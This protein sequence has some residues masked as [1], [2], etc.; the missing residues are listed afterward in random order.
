MKNFIEHS[1]SI[2]YIKAEKIY[3]HL[4]DT[5]KN[6]LYQKRKLLKK[7]QPKIKGQSGKISG[8]ILKRNGSFKSLGDFAGNEI[9]SR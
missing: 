2:E 1:I 8:S 5:L 6:K 9:Q 3:Q 7:N 4:S